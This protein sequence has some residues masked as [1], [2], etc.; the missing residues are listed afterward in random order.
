MEASLNPK[1]VCLGYT[2]K[3]SLEKGI[4]NVWEVA[5]TI[6]L[7]RPEL[8]VKVKVIGWFGDEKEE[9]IF[10][11]LISTNNGISV[12]LLG[13]QDFITFSETLKDIDIFLDLRKIDLENSRCLPI[14]LYYYIA[15][16]RPVIYSNLKAI[17]KEIE[18]NQFGY[19][20][21]P[22][23]ADLISNYILNYIDHSDIF[24]KHSH[25]ARELALNNY[26]W[27]AIEPAFLNYIQKFQ[28]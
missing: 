17:R 27:R 15:C 26:N 2:G 25:R 3:I 4:K 20:V 1:H 22:N 12:E 7:K 6:K 11:Q 13:R 5:K 24:L 10:N 19:L 21:K 8:E 16:G 18:V 14:K 23:N 28:N 9:K